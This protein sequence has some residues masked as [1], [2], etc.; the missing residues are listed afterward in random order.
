MTV[1]NISLF[2]PGNTC[3]MKLV[4]QIFEFVRGIAELDLTETAL[5]L[6]SAYIL[7]QHGKFYSQRIT[8]SIT[9]KFV[10]CNFPMDR[11]DLNFFGGDDLSFDTYLSYMYK[12][13]I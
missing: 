10:S 11:L 13:M 9:R 2:F 7:L 12:W 1:N 3:E 8:T 5:A 4:S 6:Y